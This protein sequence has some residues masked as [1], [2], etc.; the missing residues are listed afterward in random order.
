MGR[1]QRV[2]GVA[3]G[4]AV[5]IGGTIGVGILRRPGTV[6]DLLPSE[7]AI[8]GIWIAG[9]LYALLG[10]L[11]VAEL[12]TMMPRAGGFFVYAERAFG[13][14]AGFAIGWCDWLANGAAVAYG[15]IAAAEL[16][17]RFAPPTGAYH[18]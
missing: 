8:F 14:A 2:L 15:A 13:P 1:L 9:G 3:F 11:C 4:V 17:G 7:W 5:T 12:S 6:A 16:I 10:A 18:R